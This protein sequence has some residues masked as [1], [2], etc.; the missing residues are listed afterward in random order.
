MLA[1]GAWISAR[2]K[3]W[4]RGGRMR[5]PVSTVLC[6]L[7]IAS[8]FALSHL[9]LEWMG[10]H[11]DTAGGSG[12]HKIAPATY[13]CVLAIAFLALEKGP[14]PLLNDIVRRHTLTLFFAGAWAIQ[15]ANI[16]LRGG[17]ITTT[18]DTFIFPILLLV[19]VTRQTP[20]TMHVLA[21][22]IHGF[23][24]ANALL[25]LAEFVGQWRLTPIIAEGIVVVDW[26]A[27]ALLGQPLTNALATGCYALH[28]MLGGARDLPRWAVAPMIAL[29]AAAM[30]AFGGRVATALLVLF[31]AVIGVRWAIRTL[32]GRRFPIAGMAIAS[33]VV[34]MVVMSLA[35]LVSEGYL[36]K[37]LTRFTEDG[38]SA[39]SRLVMFDVFASFS[40]EEL[41]I[42]PDPGLLATRQRVYGTAFGIENF[43]LA[44]I[45]FYGLLTTIPFFLGFLCFLA[46]LRRAT[47]PQAWIVI[48]YFL[49]VC[50]SSLSLAGKSTML[51]VFVATVLILLRPDAALADT[52]PKPVRRRVRPWRQLGAF[53]A[54]R[55]SSA[56][57]S[58]S[59]VPA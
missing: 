27:S 7:S 40:F 15:F 37:F 47:R 57:P 52:A 31:A 10:F 9:M 48:A 30:V 12:F 42:G 19:L 54:R 21:L 38:G 32:S 8:A 35:Y 1:E 29:Q 23:M 16:I 44:M 39:G 41:L 50:T 24:G 51:G 36:D 5:I 34:P 46:D 59:Q 11:Y 43:W 22:T 28:L 25:A 33:L 18:F 20:Q 3:A 49:I 55:A 13:L 56:P 2:P 45:L 6:C 53:A 58:P 4:R 26:R 17:V 14:E